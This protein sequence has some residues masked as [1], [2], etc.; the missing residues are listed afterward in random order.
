[1]HDSHR[2]ANLRWCRPRCSIDLIRGDRVPIGRDHIPAG[3]TYYCIY[4]VLAQFQTTCLSFKANK[5]ASGCEAENSKLKTRNC[6]SDGSSTRAAHLVQSE[7]CA[8]A[9]TLIIFVQ[10]TTS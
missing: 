8:A 10:G 6:T 3:S 2:R 9:I 5:I 7:S 1:M 4:T